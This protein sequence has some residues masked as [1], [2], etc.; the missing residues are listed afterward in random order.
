MQPQ[1]LL[2][3]DLPFGEGG[4][5]VVVVDDAV[6][7]DL[8]ERRTLV[9]MGAADDLLEML[10]LDVDAAGDEARPAVS[11]GGLEDVGQILVDVDAARD[12]A[13]T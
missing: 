2:L 12:E 13:R 8:D 9:G 7:E 6:L 1:L 5:N 3:R 11:V 4:E 10:A